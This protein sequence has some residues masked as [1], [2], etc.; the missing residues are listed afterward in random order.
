MKTTTRPLAPRRIPRRMV[1]PRKMLY[2]RAATSNEDFDDIDEES[3]PS[4]KLSHAFIV[5]LLLHVLAVGGVFAFSSLR[6][7]Q[8][9]PDRSAKAAAAAKSAKQAQAAAEAAAAKPAPVEAAVVTY[10]VVSGDTL[11]RIASRHKTSI[12]ALEKANDI[13]STTT[14]HVGQVLR[15]P[16]EKASAAQ[17]KTEAAKT[18]AAPKTQEAAPAAKAAAPSAKE[19]AAP[20]AQEA[21]TAKPADSKADSK[22]ETKE[23]S[24][25]SDKADKTYVVAQGDN[26]YTIAKRLKVNYNDLLK[27]NKIDDPKKLQIGQKLIIP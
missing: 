1:P 6:S 15:M 16:P 3:E 8:I 4:M 2:A 11:K 23:A 20:K 27:A 12:E 22:A 5:V 25:P 9:L 13:T 7:K 14:I 21:K 26:P 10:T 19:A 24:E 17:K 18:A